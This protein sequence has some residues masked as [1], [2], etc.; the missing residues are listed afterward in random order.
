MRFDRTFAAI[1]TLALATIPAQ[2]TTYTAGEFVTF[3]A[4][5]WGAAPDGANAASLLENNFNS[6]YPQFPS[7]RWVMALIWRSEFPMLRRSSVR[8]IQIYLSR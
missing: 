3:E 1:A 5:V 8:P 2:A 7:P 6:V 4:T